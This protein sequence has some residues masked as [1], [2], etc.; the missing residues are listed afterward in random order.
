MAQRRKTWVALAVTGACLV[1]LWQWRSG[2]DDPAAS[3]TKRFA[4][5][6]WIER[7]PEN[8]RDM[9]GRFVAVRTDDGRFGAVGKGSTWRHHVELF[10]WALEEDRLTAIF[11][12]DRVRAKVRVKTWEC[13]GDAPAPFELCMELRSGERKARFYS[14]RDWKIRPKHAQGD[15]EAIAEDYPSL[16]VLA[17][18]W[19]EPQGQPEPTSL[20]DADV[21]FEPLFGL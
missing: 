12:Q 8:Q 6:V 17:E 7:M 11:P 15:L 14:M 9:F 3:R 20:R 2:A 4:N 16:S 19:V 5:Q 1:G 10:M 18:Q 21:S 13:K